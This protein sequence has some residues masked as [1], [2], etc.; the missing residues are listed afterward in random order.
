MQQEAVQAGFNLIEWT[1]V[2]KG[3][4]SLCCS[5]LIPLSA[6]FFLNIRRSKK[7]EEFRRV[8]N[9]LGI[10]L[11]EAD[12]AR[13]RVTEQFAGRDY[14][15]P[16]TMA[17]LLTMVG[18]VGLFYGADLVSFEGHIGKANFVL[19][20]T[21]WS[22]SEKEM[23]ALR[24]RNMVVLVWGFLGAF[25]WASLHITR[26]LNTGDLA[27]SVYFS[28]AIRMILAPALSLTIAFLIEASPDMIEKNV[29]AS[30][31][32]MAFLVGFF[33]DE[34]LI[35][36]RQRVPIFESAGKHAAHRLSLAMIEGITVFD[37]ARL[38]ELEIND[39]QNLATA[40]LVEIM[41]R[42][43]FSPGKVIDW[44]GQARLFLYYKEDIDALRRRQVR[45]IFDLVK[46]GD[47]GDRLRALA[48]QVN[49]S[50]SGLQF[51][52]EDARGDPTIRQLNTFKDRLC[53]GL[54]EEADEEAPRP[55][56]NE[57]TGA[58]DVKSV[59]A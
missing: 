9:V 22:L 55:P 34:A 6:I 27:P 45:T 40:D 36:L 31:P 43:P 32:A 41:V 29:E 51:V 8:V 47:D 4:L 33:P 23:Q 24:Q 53:Y 49:L 54:C 25:L 56:Q 57:R 14:Y 48:E 58:R 21:A 37:R 44:I 20:G 52:C 19:T 39:A 18:F 28:T 3:L 38:D 30:L 11:E 50:L 5:L 17:W 13:D 7:Q 46:F 35:Y 2:Y 16:V 1:T 10:A 26:R 42:T 15:T 59:R 12:F